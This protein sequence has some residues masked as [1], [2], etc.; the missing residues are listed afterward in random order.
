MDEVHKTRGKICSYVLR[1]EGDRIYCGHTKDLEVRMLQ[2]TGAAS[3][4]KICHRRSPHMNWLA[5]GTRASGMSACHRGPGGHSGPG[6]AEAGSAPGRTSP[7]PSR[8]VLHGQ[9]A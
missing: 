8:A 9:E 6:A 2:H 5:L 3:E 7:R 4:R 1:C